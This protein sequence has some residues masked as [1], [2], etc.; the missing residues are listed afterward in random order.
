MVIILCST[1][2]NVRPVTSIT[3]CLPVVPCTISMLR[4]GRSNSSDNNSMSEALAAPSTGR[5][6]RY[7]RIL[8]LS[9]SR[10]FLLLCGMTRTLIRI[11]CLS[12]H[13]A[14]HHNCSI[15]PCVHRV[16]HI[17]NVGTLIIIVRSW[18]IY[19][20]DLIDGR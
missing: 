18:C 2:S 17:L 8:S 3:F 11:R 12:S 9:H 10:L 5:A 13:L 4:L 20:N 1:S 16:F 6:V 19:R 15:T 7:A 14:S